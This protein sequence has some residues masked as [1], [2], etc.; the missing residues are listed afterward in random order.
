MNRSIVLRYGNI[1]KIEGKFRA[2][3]CIVEEKIALQT[4]LGGWDYEKWKSNLKTSTGFIDKLFD[5]RTW[6]NYK[7]AAVIHSSVVTN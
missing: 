2:V 3:M 4:I 5:Q 7:C 6:T 1:G